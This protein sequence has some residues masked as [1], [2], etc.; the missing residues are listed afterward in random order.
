[1]TLT[2]TYPTGLGKLKYTKELTLKSG[3]KVFVFEPP[4]DAIDAGVVSRCRF[5]DG[6]SARFEIPKLVEKVEAFR[7]GE[8]VAGNLGRSSTFNQIA[9]HYKDSHSFLS[10]ARS[11]QLT[12]ENKLMNVLTTDLGGKPFGD[13]KI[14]DLNA[15]MCN[16]LYQKW[17]NEVSVASA[18]AN[19]RVFSV[20]LNYCKSLDLIDTNPMAKVKKIKHTPR[21]VTWKEEY[22]YK[23]ID[24]AMTQFKWRN[25]GLMAAMCYEWSQRPNDI[26]LLK[27][28]SLD[29]E[30][31]KVKI[32]QTKRGATVELPI[33]DELKEMLTEQEKDWGFQ[34]YV[35]PL[36]RPADGAYRPMEREQVSDL[37]NQ[38]KEAA[39]L[40]QELWIGD[41][42]KTAIVEM[43][44]AGVDSLQIMSVT[45]HRNVQSLNPY[46]KHTYNAA[47]SALDM[48]KKR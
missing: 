47:K 46:Y 6:R 38:V 29:L 30:A 34:E 48:R 28:S 43:I 36:Q 26:R 18:N 45:G 20:L 19:A 40:P 44:D 4:Q 14:K 2:M 7:R 21:Y 24:T 5:H 42:R 23:F 32:K 41:L 25:I 33:S 1:M 3:K 9:K 27:W 12:Y 15:M 37:A 31:G 10:L 22:V 17:V 13:R 11:S 39:G 16:S 8:I 35:V